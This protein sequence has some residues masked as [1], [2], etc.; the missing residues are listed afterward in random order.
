MEFTGERFIPTADLL[1][2]EIGY[3]HLHRYYSIAPILKGKK[4]LDIA[5]GEGYGTAIIAAFATSAVGVDIDEE[6]IKLAVEKYTIKQNNIEFKYGSATNIPYENELF[7]VVVSFE[8]IEHLSIEMQQQFMLEIKRVLRPE[9]VLVMSTPDTVNYSERFGHDNT[10]HLHEF[11]KQ[12]Y[13]DFIDAHFKYSSIFYQ[14]YEVVS[15]ISNELS[16]N[17]KNINVYNWQNVENNKNISRKYMIAIASDKTL[18][19]EYN[20]ISSIVP[21]VNKDYLH[22]MSRLVTMNEEIETLGKWGKS[23]DFEILNLQEDKK[24]K[25]QRLSNKIGEQSNAINEQSNKIDEQSNKI[26]EHLNKTKELSDKIAAQK[27]ELLDLLQ[28]KFLLKQ[29]LVVAEM[30]LKEIHDS[31]GWYYISK[32]N[33]LKKNYLSNDSPINIKINGFINKFKKN[34]NVQKENITDV[35]FKKQADPKIHLKE[36]INYT[37]TLNLPFYNTPLVSIIIP[38][39]NGWEM[40]YRCIKSIIENT[41]PISYEII[42]ADDCSTDKTKDCT[43]IIKNIV[44]VRNAKNL[45]FLGNCNNAALSAKGEYVLFLNNDIEVTPLWLS[46]LV[47]LIESDNRI[48]LV[49]PKLVYPDGRLQEAGGIIWDDASGWNYGRNQDPTASEYNYVKE[50]D[51]ISGACILLSKKLWQEIGG[52][53]TVYAPAYYEDSDLSFTIRKLGYKVM[54]QPLSQIIHYEGFSHGTDEMIMEGDLNNIKSIQLINK[55]KFFSKWESVLTKEQY[56]NGENVFVARDRNRNKKTIVVIDHYVPHYDKDAGSRSTF[57][58]LK[59]LVSLGLNVKFIGDNFYRHEPYTTS[60]QQL[61]I[62]VLYGNWYHDNWKEW[63]INNAQNIDFFY[64]H[65]PHITLKY[66]DFLKQNTTAKILYLG[67]DLHYLREQR[68]YEL[69]QKPELL[70]SSKQWK[71]TEKYIFSY[72]DIILTFSEVEKKIIASLDPLFKVEKLLLNY[73]NNEVV[74]INDFKER[75]NILFVGGFGHTPNVDAM[76]WF[77]NEIWPLIILENIGATLII[78]GSN[79]PNAILGLASDSINIKG[80]VSEEQLKD[81]YSSIKLAIVPL[82]F[83]AGVKGKTVEALYHGLPI[84]STNIGIE[85]MPGNYDFL[86]PFDDAKSFAAEVVSLYNNEIRLQNFSSDAVE[87]INT[88]FTKDA[89]AKKMKSLLE[90]N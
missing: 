73:F 85:G 87:Y 39:F 81:L 4:V 82:R 47:D 35:N 11:N 67:H 37:Q 15:I 71:E 64:L 48:G 86:K 42:L 20:E 6:A 21:N 58:Y 70:E 2:D 89:A 28:S 53:D 27:K 88:Y 68:Q 13:I 62:E 54:Y 16:E 36:K 50:V 38:V 33:N 26:D 63:I 25:I 76:I 31:K 77:C 44:H 9:G 30:D 1:N 57:Q 19:N 46:S 18:A 29:Q 3:E 14:G 17:T 59:L 34:K 84:V 79:P 5:C 74:S 49:G 41:Q 55:D 7:D 80:F 65:R 72:A 69:T 45:G 23:L 10:F 51:Y 56:P 12:E 24:E 8:T 66:I 75:K 43:S 90:L 32:I 40:N 83:G 78:A 52:F 61:G 60:L 22:I